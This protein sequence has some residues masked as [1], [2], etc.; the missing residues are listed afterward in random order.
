MDIDDVH[1]IFA[2]ELGDAIFSEEFEGL[3]SRHEW[4]DE[5]WGYLE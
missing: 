5:E 4:T 2:Y 1:F 3:P